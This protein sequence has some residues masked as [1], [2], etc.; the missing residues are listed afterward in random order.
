MQLAGEEVN[1]AA[2]QFSFC[3]ALFEALYGVRPYPHSKLRALAEAYER[4]DVVSP[5]PGS[6]ISACCCSVTWL[7]CS[8]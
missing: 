3:V 8:R 1:A 2:D 4:E 7:S 6:P 5:A